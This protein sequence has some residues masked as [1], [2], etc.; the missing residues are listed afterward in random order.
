[1]LAPLDKDYLSAL[2]DQLLHQ[3][4][5]FK[6]QA[7]MVDVIYVFTTTTQKRIRDPMPFSC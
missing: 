6:I 2:H 1:M 4:L 3:K 5:K 7:K